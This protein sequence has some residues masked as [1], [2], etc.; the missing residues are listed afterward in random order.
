[1]LYFL[2]LT[3]LQYSCSETDNHS[4]SDLYCFLL[5]HISPQNFPIS[6]LVGALTT[7]VLPS[8]LNFLYT[9]F[10]LVLNCL[11]IVSLSLTAFLF[12]S[13]L[14]NTL[15]FCFR[16]VSVFSR[17]SFVV[18]PYHFLSFLSMFLWCWV[19]LPSFLH[20]KIKST[21]ASRLLVESILCSSCICH[22]GLSLFLIFFVSCDFPSCSS[23]VITIL[24][25]HNDTPSRSLYVL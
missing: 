13:F 8:A 12:L 6:S 16:V 20:R 25:S 19:Y 3:P 17:F 4:A 7:L 10:G 23:R 9:A 18:L 21:K 15:S 5:F 14:V 2:Y 22:P 24:M 11:F 1:M